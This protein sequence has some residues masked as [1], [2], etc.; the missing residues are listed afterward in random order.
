VVRPVS[1]I[2][3]SRNRVEATQENKVR[4]H[5]VIIHLFKKNLLRTVFGPGREIT[6][7]RMLHNEQIRVNVPLAVVFNVWTQS[8][9]VKHEGKKVKSLST[10]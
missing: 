10:P 2:A 3:M 4:N 5:E 8:R 1:V 9:A 7:K 6:E